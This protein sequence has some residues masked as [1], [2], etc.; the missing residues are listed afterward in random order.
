MD[1]WV[2]RELETQPVTK[3]EGEREEEV[4]LCIG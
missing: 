1:V 3:V 4:T 2:W